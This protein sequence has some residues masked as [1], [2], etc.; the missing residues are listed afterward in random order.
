METQTQQHDDYHAAATS[1][2][3]AGC[4]CAGCVRERRRLASV[5]YREAVTRIGG[6]LDELGREVN[7]Q[8][9]IVQA[10]A[11][12]ARVAALEFETTGGEGD[13]EAF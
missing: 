4:G 6:I 8:P 10:L 3:L 2:M 11:R 12:A 5:L 7:Y 9:E 1:E 13:Q